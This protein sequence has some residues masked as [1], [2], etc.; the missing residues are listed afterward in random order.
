MAR[1]SAL[2]FS[3]HANPAEQTPL[4]LTVKAILTRR[5]RHHTKISIIVALVFILITTPIGLLSW[6]RPALSSIAQLLTLPALPVVYGLVQAFPPP[7]GESE[8]S[9]WD[10]MMLSVGILVSAL[11][12]GLVAGLL[13]RY[14]R[15][16]PDDTGS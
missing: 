11:I 9:P 6:N 15:A 2:R 12:W 3:T 1:R 13:S 14:F 5:M 16:K 7:M 10:Y 8:S 4:P